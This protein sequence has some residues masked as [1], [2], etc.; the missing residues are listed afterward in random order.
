MEKSEKITPS[1][2]FFLGIFFISAS[3]VIFEIVITR[4]SSVIFTYNYAFIAVSLAILGLGC[5]GIFAYYRYNPK[6]LYK[7]FEILSRLSFYSC[8]FSIFTAL[9]II[10]ITKVLFFLN[11]FL[12]FTSAFIPYFFAGIVLSLTF[13]MFS[14][15]SYKLYFSDLLGAAA[16]AVLSI[17]ILK[18]FGGVNS[19]IFI[20]ILGVISAFLFITNYSRK[21]INLSSIRFSLI[22]SVVVLTVF[23]LNSFL[24]FLGEIPIKKSDIK[25]LYLMLNSS[26]A[27][28]E[29]VESRWSV[30]GRVDLAEVKGDDKVKYLFIDGASGTPMFKFDGNIKEANNTLDFLKMIFSGTFPFYFLNENQKDNMLIVGPGGGREVVIGLVNGIKNITGVEINNDFVNIVKEYKDYNGGIYTNFSNVNIITAEGRSYLRSINTKFDTIMIVQPFTKSSRSLEGYT[31]TENYLLTVGAIKD[32]MSHMTKEGNLIIVLHNANEMM[33][34]ITSLLSALEEMGI[35]N[36]K[37]MNYFYTVGRGD[38]NPVLVLRNTPFTTEESK[39]ILNKM[40]DLRLISPLEFIP[41]LGQVIVS[42][43]KEDGTIVKGKIFDEDL[44]LVESGKLKLNDLILKSTFNIKPTTDNRPYFFKDEKGIP[45]N[46]IPILII[47][48][49]INI[50]MIILS[51]IQSRSS[52]GNRGILKLMLL[53]LL[54]GF[55]F[56]MIEIS[57]YQKLILYIGSPIIALAVILGMLLAGMGLGS[58]LGEKIFPNDNMKRLI[59]ITL[60]ISVIVAVLFFALSLIL[61]NS[62]GYNTYLKGLICCAVILPIGFTMGIPFPTGIRIAKENGAASFITWMYGINGTMSVLGSVS[63]I[64]ISTVFGFTASLIVGSFC[65]LAIAFIFIFGVKK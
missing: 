32:Y 10:L 57:F 12:Y 62:L 21:S 13:Q 48:I 55:G 11:L 4:I 14:T 34:F 6:R 27:K 38:I 1:F 63:A 24:S 17:P 51:V 15:Y 43:E 22:V 39:N 46:I 37:A 58:L 50:F 26:D 56:M 53:A 54:L 35:S 5:G 7:P 60:I 25:D 47:A 23:I 36:A 61:N 40:L 41:G 65:Y 42:F 19:I 49:I 9:F 28:A 44:L 20:G 2:R 29:I 30:F 59:T 8:L 64:A 18:I 52:K 31:L 16:G 45:V 3:V 33:R